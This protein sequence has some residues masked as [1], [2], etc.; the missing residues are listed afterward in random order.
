MGLLGLAKQEL[1][2]V[3]EDEAERSLLIRG[4][5]RRSGSR[6]RRDGDLSVGGMLKLSEMGG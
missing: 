3:T 2:T 4:S 1:T 6:V 5:S